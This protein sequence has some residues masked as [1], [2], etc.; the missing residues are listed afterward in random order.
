MAGETKYHPDD[1]R[2]LVDALKCCRAALEAEH[3]DEVAAEMF[4][5]EPDPERAMK[6][7]RSDCIDM[8]N[9]ALLTF[10][11]RAALSPTA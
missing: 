6:I 1:V 7:N 10:A 9:E 8:A 3:H 2:R 5:G 11:T 4:G